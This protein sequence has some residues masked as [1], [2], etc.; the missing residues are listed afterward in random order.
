MQ[1][2]QAA[3]EPRGIT[4]LVVDNNQS[5]REET[6]RLLHDCGYKVVAAQRGSE[7]LQLLAD[8]VAATGSPGVDLILKDH[9][10]P[11]TNSVR[12]LHRLK[13]RQELSKTPCI[14]VSNQDS[15]DVVL[16]CLS[17]GAADYWV[18]PIRPNEIRMLWTRVWRGNQPPG[19]L[20]A[21]D[22]SN[23]GNSTDA[24]AVLEDVEPTSK[25]GSAPDSV[26]NGQYQQL[27]GA[28]SGSG[29]NGNAAAAVAA[30]GQANGSSGHTGKEGSNTGDGGSAGGDAGSG[31]ADNGSRDA[32]NGSGGD[33]GHGSN[34]NGN[35]C[36]ASTTAQPAAL[37]MPPLPPSHQRSHHH[38]RHHS[39]HHRSHHRQ[40][41]AGTEAGSEAPYAFQPLM[42]AQEA[43][44][45]RAAAGALPSPAQQSA[46]AAD[47]FP[48]PPPRPRLLP[49]QQ[50][51]QPAQEQQM[52]AA[53]PAA[54]AAAPN[55]AAAMA[56]AE[57]EAG[58]GPASLQQAAAAGETAAAAQQQERRQQQQQLLRQQV[59]EE[60]E[61][62]ERQR[63]VN[64]IADIAEALTSLRDSGS[65]R[66]S[67]GGAAGGGAVAAPS[68]AAPGL[69]PMSGRITRSSRAAAAV[70]GVKGHGA[71][72]QP[73]SFTTASADT[74]LGHHHHHHPQQQHPAPMSPLA[75][76]QQPELLTHGSASQPP[77]LALP[78]QQAPAQQ[79]Q[80][81]MPFPASLMQ[82]FGLVGGMPPFMPQQ[83][84]FGWGAGM[85]ASMAGMPSVAQQ[86][87]Q[88][89]AQQQQQQ[90]QQ[91]FAQHQQFLHHQHQQ[92]QQQFAQQAQLQA[93]AQAQAQAKA[94]ACAGLSLEQPKAEADAAQQAAAPAAA[95]DAA[96]EGDAAGVASAHQSMQAAAYAEQAQQHQRAMF[97]QQQA[98][99]HAQQQGQQQVHY[100]WM[101]QQYSMA[102]VA[103]AAA[104]QPP[105]LPPPPPPGMGGTMGGSM[106]GPG[107]CQP[108][109]WPQQRQQMP[110]HQQLPPGLSFSGLSLPAPSSAVAAAAFQPAATVTAGLLPG[111]QGALS[112]PSTL[113]PLAPLNLSGETFSKKEARLQA[114]AK[115]REKRKKLNFGKKIRYQT[116]KALADQRPRVRGQF[117]RMPK[118]EAASNGAN[119]NGGG[120]SSRE[121]LLAEQQAASGATASGGQLPLADALVAAVAAAAELPFAAEEPQP[122]TMQEGTVEDQEYEQ[123]GADVEDDEEEDEEEDYEEE[124]E[125]EEDEEMAG[126]AGKA[127]AMGQGKPPR[128]Q[129]A[130]L[131][132][133]ESQSATQSFGGSGS[134]RRQGRTPLH[135]HHQLAA[136]AAAAAAASPVAPSAD[137]GSGGGSQTA[138]TTSSDGAEDELL[139]EATPATW[140]QQLHKQLSGHKHR[141]DGAVLAGAADKR[142]GSDSG[143]NSPG[144]QTPV[145]DSRLEAE[146]EDAAARL[147]PAKLPRGRK[148]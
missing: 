7:A 83:A 139:P 32:E 127:Q 76:K 20:P 47:P 97:V 138:G 46:A 73:E 72:S 4:V 74:G 52:A 90:A 24:A 136:A 53:V 22:D 45:A 82:Q 29:V 57:L 137:G 79:Q 147:R 61:E 89:H 1:T 42:A 36:D 69:S 123:P 51:Q 100:A 93:Q 39:H 96:G 114:Y 56:A 91:Q 28:G 34:G 37:G 14:V 49:E 40:S 11:A 141:R 63:G 143:S 12:F 18:R 16:K 109:G 148:K 64:E 111:L 67:S 106:A 133:Y 3:L 104:G 116:R 30:N 134:H 122:D 21:S 44:A 80:A 25:E 86:Q 144:D 48:S 70:G 17:S 26:R 9:D 6:L 38:H 103:A 77:V 146:A 131:K 35:G 107:F 130:H 135:P 23:S 55:A 54:A 8:R 99:A 58:A 140:Q 142:N 115:Y 13:E 101:L 75:A 94:A 66:H 98:H 121:Q 125:E 95:G 78:Q 68:A 62:E 87:Q 65:P 118:E 5:S 108:M 2:T 41:S 19:Q 81:Q 110:W 31:G 126:A 112:L 119:G 50:Q 92:L 129:S 43:A 145:P 59:V 105:P 85:G 71:R 102:A 128:R 132:Q 84:G 124:E 10:P 113:P 33:N 27:Q 120:A 15:R 117:V 60:A 88:Q